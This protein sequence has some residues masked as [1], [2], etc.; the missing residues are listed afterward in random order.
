MTTKRPV[1]DVDVPDIQQCPNCGNHVFLG[2]TECSRCGQD[3]SNWEQKVREFDLR[4]AGILLILVGLLATFSAFSSADT[5]KA[6]LLVVGIGFI[7]GG[8]LTA[9]A[10]YFLEDILNQIKR[11]TKKK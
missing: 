10:D 3:V 9:T 2:E 1:S 5:Q 6:I 7:I 11:L 8:G 4:I